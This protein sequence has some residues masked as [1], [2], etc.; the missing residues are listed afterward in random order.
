MSGWRR[1]SYAISM[2][3]L[4]TALAYPFVPGIGEF[5]ALP[6]MVLEGWLYLVV[7]A[8]SEDEYPPHIGNWMVFSVLFYSVLIYFALL[9]YASVKRQK[10]Q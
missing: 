10:A 2:A 5:L 1:L 9:I 3:V 4:L 7:L 6:G 8:L